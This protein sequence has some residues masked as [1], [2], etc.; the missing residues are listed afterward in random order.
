MSLRISFAA[1]LQFLRMR[2][3][4][5]QQELGQAADQSYVS[6]LESGAR[7]VTLEVSDDLAKALGVDPLT[8]LLLTYASERGETPQQVLE[9][10]RKDLTVSGLL[11]T[12]IPSQASKAPHPMVAASEELRPQIKALADQGLGQTEIAKRLGISRHTVINHLKKMG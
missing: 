8:L 12:D 10:L 2:Q 11:T 6:R 3:A 7:S 9:H 5:L 4:S 1:A